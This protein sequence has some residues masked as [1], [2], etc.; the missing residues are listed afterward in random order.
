MNDTVMCI[1]GQTHSN[2]IE[3]T[4]Y[5]SQDGYTPLYVSSQKGHVEVV[6]ALLAA[7]VDKDKADKVN[8]MK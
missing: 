7:G 4:C 1:Y 3:I 6:K 5:I 2:D 8:E